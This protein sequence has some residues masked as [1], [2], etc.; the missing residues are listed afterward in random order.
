MLTL[1]SS[2]NFFIYA[3]A[4]PDFRKV[5]IET[6]R[7]AIWNPVCRTFCANMAYSETDEIELQNAAPL[8]QAEDCDRNENDRGQQTEQEPENRN[9]EADIEGSMIETAV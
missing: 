9:L 2:M 6:V 7:K 5:L 4:S 8:L 3:L 1:N